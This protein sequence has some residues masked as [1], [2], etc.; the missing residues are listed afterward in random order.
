MDFKKAY[1]S[2]RREILY[3]ILIKSGIPMKL[4]RLIKT[5]LNETYSKFHIGKHLSAKFPIKNGLKQADILSPLLFNFALEYVI[6]K[7][8]E[9]RVGLKLNETHPLL[10]SADSMNLLGYNIDTIKKNTQTLIDASKEVGLEVNAEKT[11]YMLL[12][13]TQNAGQN[14]DIKTDNRF[15]ESAAKFRYLGTTVT[16]QNDS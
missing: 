7:V 16:N 1:D 13:R 9:N 12:S 4:V 2:V 8:Q 15:F 14:H 3:N 11:K 6:W 5:C 10:G